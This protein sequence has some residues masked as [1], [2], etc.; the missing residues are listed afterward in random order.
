[1]TILFAVAAVLGF[2]IIQNMQDGAA[3]DVRNFD[4]GFIISDDLMGDYT[5]MSEAEIYNFLKSKNHCNDR[6][7]V[8]AS[9]YPNLSYHIENGHFVCM[10]DEKFDG[11]SS[12]HIIWQAAQDYRIS[13]KVLIV[14]LEKE[15][16][17]VSDTW[18][19]SNLQYR[20]ATG[21]GCPDTAA[22]D[23]QYYGFKNQVRNA[24]KF[25]RKNLDGDPN[26]TNYPIGLNNILYCPDYGC[27]TKQ[28]NIKNRATGA[29]YTYT[30]YT[31]NNA[32]LNAGY[33]LGDGCSAYGNR[34][35]WL[36]YND[37][38]GDSRASVPL[39]R[40]TEGI[41]KT[42]EKVSGESK[43]GKAVG[44]ISSNLS[45]GIY[46]QQYEKGY[47]V[48]KDS[49]GYFI[50][51]GKI[52]EVWSK[53]GFE[54]GSLGFPVANIESNPKTGISWQQYEHGFIVGKDSTGYY[55]S[56]GKIRDAWA[57]QNFE[58]GSLGFPISNIDYNPSTGIYWQQYEKGYIVGRDSTG[59][60][61]STGK[62]REVWSKQGFEAGSL[63]FPVANIESNPKTGISWQ[64]YEHGFIV[65]KDSTGYYVS[66]GKI[67]EIWAEQDFERG[68]LGFPTSAITRHSDTGIYTQNYEH[69]V[70]LFNESARQTAILF[71]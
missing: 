12:S 36:L 39:A 3:A 43:L 37:W 28:V 42:Y 66:Q 55:V 31:P 21:Y 65:G 63:G 49:T 29:L 14:L 13:P 40:A 51:T 1:M 59:Y 8:K 18:P 70:I 6:D 34:N 9:W 68:K 47:I 53:Q 33:G 30:P 71:Y 11:E 54:A 50:S 17:L 10:A 25:F 22:C 7:T 41:E 62:I 57:N 4:P 35:F 69:G 67:R 61:I 60:F 5:S 27:G 23:S 20:S 46:W 15:Q 26:W 38:F 44:N 56:Q 58:S 45:T 2:R 52:R 24:A 32:A 19:N 16:G 64:Q 48:G